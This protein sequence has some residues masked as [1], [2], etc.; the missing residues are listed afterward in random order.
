[1][2]NLLANIELPEFVTEL[3]EEFTTAP[4][5]RAH[6]ETAEHREFFST[7]S[8]RAYDAFIEVEHFNDLHDIA[9]YA[10]TVNVSDE[11]IAIYACASVEEA[12]IVA[13]R[14]AIALTVAASK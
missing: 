7:I 14:V 9:C 8:L 10:V 2:K 6:L 13:H 12:F 1:M 5:A 11:I 4:A 3:S